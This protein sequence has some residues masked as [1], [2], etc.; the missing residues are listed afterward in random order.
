V[1]TLVALLLTAMA[2]S[3]RTRGAGV[4]G[5][6]GKASAATA[7]GEGG[8]PV[9]PRVASAA[10]AKARPAPAKPTRAGELAS[11]PAGRLA[12]GSTPGDEGREPR[13]EPAL[14][15][16]SLD[17][18]EIDRLAYPNDPALPPRTNVTRT[19]AARLCADR[20]ERLCS[21]LEWEYACKSA[22]SD[23]YAGGDQWPSECARDA[24]ACA[25]RLGVLGLGAL[26]EW[27]ASDLSPLEKSE[28]KLAVVRGADA[29]APT[30]DHRCAH[31]SGSDASRR[32]ERTGLR[33]CRGAPNPAS[34]AAP[35]LGPTAKRAGLS[36]AKVSEILATIPELAS[37]P[38]P[39]RFFA[40]P[41]DTATV[42]RRG[43]AK[44]S[45][46][47]GFTLTTS[48]L[49]WNPAPGDELLVILGRSGRD[50]FIA[51]LY[52]LPGDRYR[53]AASLL[54]AS[55]QGPFALAYH[56][57]IRERI[58][59]SSCWKCQGEGGTVALRD[60]RRVVI[61]QQ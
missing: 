53:L 47:D 9:L 35:R 24:K 31:R 17:A 19:Q 59:W 14:F 6:A 39:V 8:A 20:G 5:D 15:D 50:S 51:A 1:R 34:V 44:T 27:T 11:L 33:C 26:R 36:S 61:V 25:S 38:G 28:P 43:K 7:S 54:F 49:V 30:T 32:D 56:P 12:A 57:E 58:I 2:A 10:A 37:L 29:D 60:A 40:E 52:Q 45:D 3:C 16:V 18:F 21:E 42:L 22:L 13:V 41:D 23:A 46:L 55:D 48:P 4:G